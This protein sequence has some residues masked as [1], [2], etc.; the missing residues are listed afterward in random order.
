MKKAVGR[1][2]LEGK[3]FAEIEEDN[4]KVIK[5]FLQLSDEEFKEVYEK[6]EIEM[7]VERA[8]AETGLYY[9]QVTFRIPQG[10]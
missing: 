2:A 10:E 3:T 4:S 8:S 7:V 6:L 5:D 9:G 1:I